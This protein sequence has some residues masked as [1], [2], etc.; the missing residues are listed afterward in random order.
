MAGGANKLFLKQPEQFLKANLIAINVSDQELLKVAAR[1]ADPAKAV[2]APTGR[3]AN[4]GLAAAVPATLKAAGI[5]DFDLIKSPTTAEV[6]VNGVA[7]QIPMYKLEAWGR[8]TRDQKLLR[9]GDLQSVQYKKPWFAHPIRAFWLPWS[10]DSSWSA[11]LGPQADFFFT[12]TMDG[13]SLAI[14]SG[15]APVV[16]HSNYKS[17][18]N[19][20]VASEGLT[21]YRIQQQHAALGVDVQRAL[22]KGQY[23]A[24]ANQKTRGI[25][26][27]V[28]V[29]GIRNTTANTWT[30]Y[31]QR[32]KVILGDPARGTHN[33]TLLMDRLVPIL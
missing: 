21:K 11:Q 23:A 28:T 27:L 6:V 4:Q 12:P 16:T 8:K 3:L 2:I 10:S 14:S 18:Q 20:N 15:A 26:Q 19:A 17:T 7:T 32:R 24:S 33:R 5:Y 31:W 1:N 29:V 9:P 22:L 13:C 30:F 25:N